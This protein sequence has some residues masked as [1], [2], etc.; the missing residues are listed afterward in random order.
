M[1]DTSQISQ[2]TLALFTAAAKA[3]RRGDPRLIKATTA[4]ISQATGLVWYDL[5]RPAKN[6]FP[7]L[8]PLRNR[9]PRVQGNGDTATRWKAVT[10]I[11]VNKLR[12]GVPEGMRNGIVSTTEVDKL[13]AYKT[14]G[15]EDFVTFEALNAAKNFED[16]RSTTAQRLLWATMIQE[17]VLDL[18]GNSDQGV[19]LGITPTPAVTA[20]ATGGT[21]ANG[22]YNMIC[23]ALTH[24]GWMASSLAAGVPDVQ[25]VT[26]ADGDSFTYKPGTAQQSAGTAYTITGT[27]I[28]S[29]AASVAAVPGAV[30]YAWYSGP[31]GSERLQAITTIN[32]VLLTALSGTNQLIGTKFTADSSQNVYEWDGLMTHVFKT[33][34][35]S[36]VS[37]LPTGTAGTGTKLTAANTD[38]SIDQIQ[39]VL[40]AMWDQYRI[41]PS[42]MYVSA[43][44]VQ[45]ISALVIKNNGSP[46]IRLTG[47]FSQGIDGMVAGSVVGSYLNRFGMSGGQLMRIQ[48]HPNAAP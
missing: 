44:E 33:G 39:T 18:G 5:Q 7:V 37:T 47:D 9:I 11:N 26:T 23:V 29:V 42:V 3:G 2:E 36:V 1:Q 40:R 45:N 17:E 41:S 46:I 20:N 24:G 43:Q 4:G 34:S 27:N 16:I 22:T 30:A 10:G 8:T 6:L 25:S 35:G 15:L 28:G 21:I 32:S 38:A 48:L 19:A 12:G 13:Q 31:A 14:V